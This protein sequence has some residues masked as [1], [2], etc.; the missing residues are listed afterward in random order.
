MSKKSIFSS[1]TTR[2]E[3]SEKLIQGTDMPVVN[4]SSSKTNVAELRKI[5][6]GRAPVYKNKE[7]PWYGTMFKKNTK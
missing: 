3:K 7:Q 5:E 4:P 1:K 2:K 6:K